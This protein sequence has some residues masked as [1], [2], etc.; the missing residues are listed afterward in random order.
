MAFGFV[1]ARFGLFLQVLRVDS[2]GKLPS[3]STSEGLGL[4]FAVF[5]CLLA[6]LGVWRFLVNARAL[7]QDK[8]YPG[9]RINALVGW[10]TVL[11]GIG[12]VLALLRVI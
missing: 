12:V 3:T 10:L 5:G 9:A 7:A 2:A 11:L 6:I 8:F 4:A 1:I